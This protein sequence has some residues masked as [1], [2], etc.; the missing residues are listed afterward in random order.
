MPASGAAPRPNAILDPSEAEFLGNLVNTISLQSVA[1]L[2]SR[3]PQSNQQSK[4]PKS[5]GLV[6]LGASLSKAEAMAK[7]HTAETLIGALAD[8]AATTKRQ[9]VETRIDP[10]A[11][12]NLAANGTSWLVE[13]LRCWQLALDY[14]PNAAMRL[15]E[16]VIAAHRAQSTTIGR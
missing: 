12:S 14:N 4:S 16:L 8:A 5:D 9:L 6:A 7:A 15:C 13:R 3:A 11:P 10:Q 2:V 1:S